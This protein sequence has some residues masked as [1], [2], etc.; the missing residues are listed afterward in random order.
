MSHFR[1]REDPWRAVGGSVF[2]F[3]LSS[4]VVCCLSAVVLQAAALERAPFC[5]VPLEEA[6]ASSSP[7][8]EGGIPPVP[9]VAS[10]RGQAQLGNAP[11]C[12][13]PSAV[14]DPLPDN[15][16]VAR[17][18]ARES[19]FV[20]AALAASRHLAAHPLRGPPRLPS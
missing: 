7:E 18:T 6:Q 12:G 5:T 19:A 20:A 3:R 14:G 17:P 2:E 8:P 4:A 11:P 1:E 13:G 15:L 10:R 9:S 16:A